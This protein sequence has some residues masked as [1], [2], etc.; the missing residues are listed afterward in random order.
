MNYGPLTK[1]LV[2]FYKG[3]RPMKL[4]VNSIAISILSISAHCHADPAGDLAKVRELANTI[5][6]GSDVRKTITRYKNT[7][8]NPCAAEGITYI[9]NV[10]IRKSVLKELPS[11]AIGQSREWQDFNQYHISEVDLQSG[12]KL[13][14]AICQE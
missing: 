12:K 14:D 9:V 11:G 1:P 6:S 5:I 3:N 8:G 7:D 13:S 4:L 10:Q 2:D